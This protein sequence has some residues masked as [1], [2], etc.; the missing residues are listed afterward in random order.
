MEMNSATPLS[1]P[2]D[3]KINGRFFG[4]ILL[5][6]KP[7]WTGRSSRRAWLVFACVTGFALFE[8]AVGAKI[9]FLTKT[10]TDALVSKHEMSY[11]H[12]LAMI[13]ALGIF[14]QGGVITQVFQYLNGWLLQDWRRTLTRYIVDRYLA[15]RTYFRIEQDSDID[16]VDQRMQQESTQYCSMMTLLPQVLV[17]TVSGV[18][19]QGWILMTISPTLFYGVLVYGIG[20]AVLTWWLYGP[21]IRFNFDSTV[22]EA[23]LRFGML[24]V[25]THAETVALYRGERA[26]QSSIDKRLTRAVRVALKVIKYQVILNSV[27][28]VLSA[29]W[30]LVPVLVLVPLYFS[31]KVTFGVVTQGIASAGLLLTAIRRF[32]T[33]IPLFAQTAPHVVRLAQIVEKANAVER[34]SVDTSRSIRFAV[35]PTIGVESVTLHTPGRERTLLR[36]LT[37][38][39]GPR[40]SLLIV[41]QTG[42]GKSSLLRAMAG[43]WREGAGTISM[44][45]AEQVLFL[46]Q[47]PYMLLG[48]LREQLLYPHVERSLSDAELQRM[49]EDV[50]LPELANRHGGF[51]AVIDWGRVLSL[52]EQQRVGFARALASR[53]SYV[54]L[55][56]A[57]SAVDVKT[58]RVL[59]EALAKRGIT[60]VSVGHRLSLTAY[61]TKVL[62]LRA[63]GAWRCITSAEAQAE[64]AALAT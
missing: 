13:T 52:G 26:E 34:E 48:S 42:V 53:C 2:K 6:A 24:H 32:T 44:P 35:G 40:D 4:R 10:M 31:G 1:D 23:D 46:P 43:L 7:Y 37:L 20:T 50:N 5:L 51:D 28:N 55:D 38:H 27:E 41:G 62:E 14:V 45:Q 63:Q 21:L 58:E 29:V 59:Y 9:S 17:Y 56:E 12:L 3:Y 8:A 47:R 16:N 11:W 64:A 57:T 22:A 39:I 25:R 36:D 61:H 15:A 49:L 30:T 19:V 18:S 60:Y 33:F 54:I